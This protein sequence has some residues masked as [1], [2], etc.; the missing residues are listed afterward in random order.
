MK[1]ES[2]KGK[3]LHGKQWKKAVRKLFGKDFMIRHRELTARDVRQEAKELR[4][5]ILM[6]KKQLGPSVHK[7]KGQ[8]IAHVLRE[9]NKVVD[10]LT[11]LLAMVGDD[12]QEHESGGGEG[13]ACE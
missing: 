10:R 9:S 1:I 5:E 8:G 3:A 11:K 4:I 12:S 7:S 13:V 2:K 6:G